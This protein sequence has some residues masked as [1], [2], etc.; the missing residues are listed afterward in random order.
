MFAAALAVGIAMQ[1]A[2]ALALTLKE[3]TT[4]VDL[5]EALEPQLGD[6]AYDDEIAEYWFEEDSYGEGWIA[7]AGFTAET[8]NRALGETMRG[9]M[10]LMPDAE[11]EA[12]FAGLKQGI[13]ALPQLTEAQKAEALAAIDEEIA[14]FLARRAEGEPFAPIVKPLED[15]LRRLTL[16]EA[17]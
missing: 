13:E 9:F 15:R 3:A 1:P 2:G 4:V 17:E 11:V 7:K 12:T 14:S 8:W 10:A 6:F 16:D 5:I